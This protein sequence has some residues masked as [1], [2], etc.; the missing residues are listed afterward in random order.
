MTLL[1]LVKKLMRTETIIIQEA[2]GCDIYEGEVRDF[3]ETLRD[4]GFDKVEDLI[5]SEVDV[6]FTNNDKMVIVLA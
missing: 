6:V 1:T 2:T 3:I 5:T 4:A